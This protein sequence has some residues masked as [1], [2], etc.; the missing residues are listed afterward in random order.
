MLRKIRLCSGNT[1][2]YHI[3]VACYLNSRQDR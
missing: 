1:N 3:I 2:E